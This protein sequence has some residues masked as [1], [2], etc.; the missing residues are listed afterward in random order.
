MALSSNPLL[1]KH[2]K[3][4]DCEIVKLKN[5]FVISDFIVSAG[6]DF[7]YS[8]KDEDNALLL[9]VESFGTIKMEEIAKKLKESKIALVDE[10]LMEMYVYNVPTTDVINAVMKQ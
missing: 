1:N 10:K 2:F 6:V 9:N 3:E 8:I 4:Q 5:N 7:M